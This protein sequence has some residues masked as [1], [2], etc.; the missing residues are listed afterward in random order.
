M[1]S[2]SL[3]DSDFKCN[4]LYLYLVS[5]PFLA[6]DLFRGMILNSQKAPDLYPPCEGGERGGEEKA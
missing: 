6:V 4:Q 1:E 3:A 5:S 2:L